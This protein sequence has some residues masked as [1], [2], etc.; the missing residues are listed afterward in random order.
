[1]KKL[2]FLLLITG[3][4]WFS[5]KAQ[6]ES[7]GL[8]EEALLFS[9]TNPT[10]SARI[11][12]IGGAITAL[13]GDISSISTNPAGLGFYRR[14]EVSLSTRLQFSNVNSLY[15]GTSVSE[16][17][18]NFNVPNVSVV[19][20]TSVDEIHPGKW[21][22]GSFGFSY[23]RINNFNSESR[24]FTEEVPESIIQSF[25]DQAN[26]VPFFELEG[27]TDDITSL[28]EAA[29]FTFLITPRSFIDS[30]GGSDSEYF[31]DVFGSPFQ[32]E[33]TRTSG[34]QNQWNFSYGGNFDD[35]FYFG[36]NLS[37]LTI[38]YQR[39]R[40]FQEF[41]YRDPDDLVIL[42][43]LNSIETLELDGSGVNATLGLIY[44][45]NDYVRL[46]LSYTTP[47]TININREFGFD[48]EANYDDF[49]FETLEESVVLSSEF[50]ES[51]LFETEYNLR[52]P[53]RLNLGTSV[54]LGKNGFISIDAEYIDYAGANIDSDEFIADGDNQI[55][56][57]VFS[58][59]WNYR[60]G[61]E[62]RYGKI[63]LRGGYNFQGDPTNDGFNQ[64]RQTISAGIGARFNQFYGDLFYS[65]TQFDSQRTLYP[66]LE[67]PDPTA[68]IDT[69]I[70]QVGLTFGYLF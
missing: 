15:F 26:G 30:V 51:P 28:T 22:G 69:R 8:A 63:R 11:T 16:N 34:S 19:I 37:I 53:S 20:N 59:T 25:L 55:I 23:N 29:F 18:N 9:A 49:L 10:Y 46:G 33:I 60:A 65:N 54:F 62:Y 32:E 41:G 58:S 1:M 68:N 24:V 67:S 7:F 5:A 47:S 40:F 35:R 13:G 3:G 57:E 12:A 50:V 17:D 66:L 14:S 44:R 48:L 42:N 70:Q 43:D 31:T 2:A 4:V 38:N 45:L 52:T 21:R 64:E 36:F 27:T 61:I 56:D 6:T 39:E